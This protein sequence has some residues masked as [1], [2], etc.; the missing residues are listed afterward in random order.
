M[1]MGKVLRD[2]MRIAYQQWGSPDAAKKVLAVHGW[3]DNSNSFSLLGPK[4][5]SVGYHVVAIDLLGHGRSKH[6]GPEAIYTITNGVGYLNEFIEKLGWVRP[7]IVGHSMGAGISLLF[8]GTF[9]EKVNKLVLI[10]GIGPVTAADSACAKN[11]RRSL[12]AEKK[13]QLKCVE[14]NGAPWK[15]YPSMKEAVIAR[16]KSVESYPG[17]QTL[18]VE[19]AS[20]LVARGT[21]FVD[22][23][24]GRSLDVGEEDPRTSAVRF[25]HDPRMV[26][27]SRAYLSNDQ[28]LSFVDNITA[29]TL[30]I[31][32]EKGWPFESGDAVFEKRVKILS[33]KV[34]TSSRPLYL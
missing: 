29:K 22:S 1:A 11:L 32:A 9:P 5:A 16:V 12:E 14:T 4:L 28:V 3:L 34:M 31:T 24:T 18:S 30:L 23:E 17:Q 15:I 2:G 25:R 33:D 27:S 10:E 21:F 20:S 7:N 13:Y 19:A 8:S 6:I 26:L